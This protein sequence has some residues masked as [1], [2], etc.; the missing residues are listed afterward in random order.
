MF[1]QNCNAFPSS[2]TQSQ[3]NGT[4]FNPN[5]LSNILDFQYQNQTFNYNYNQPAQHF[6][7]QIPLINLI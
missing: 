3:N 7:N 4:M 6:P 5:V 1:G 2:Y